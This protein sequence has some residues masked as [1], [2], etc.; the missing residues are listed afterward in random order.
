MGCMPK[1]EVCIS[2]TGEF[3]DLGVA[4]EVIYESEIS[5]R[6]F[7]FLQKLFD[8]VRD[9]KDALGDRILLLYETIP[10]LVAQAVAKKNSS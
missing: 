1:G 9:D 10:T 3:E 6:D 7:V 8:E 5:R 4:P 2:E